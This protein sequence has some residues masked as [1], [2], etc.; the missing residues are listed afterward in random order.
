MKAV[1]SLW[2]V[3]AVIALASCKKEE[4]LGSVDN[5]SGLGGDSWAPGPIDTWI[6]DNLTTPYNIAVKY[7]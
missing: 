2:V 7:K 3:L 4:E 5:I 1:K 6:F